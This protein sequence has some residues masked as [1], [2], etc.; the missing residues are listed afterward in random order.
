MIKFKRWLWGGVA[1][2]VALT[3][4]GVGFT[5]WQ[6]AHY[7]P[8]DA[9]QSP[10]PAALAFFLD[11]YAGARK[12]FLA[13]GDGLAARFRGVERF[14]LRVPAAKSAAE[15][16]IDGL[17]IPAQVAPRRLLLVTSGVHGVEG[18]TGSAVQRM[19][20]KEFHTR[21]AGRDRCAAGARGQPLGFCERPTLH[22]EQRGPQPQC[23]HRGCALP[24][25]ERGL[26]HGQPDDQPG[27]AGGHGRPGQ[28]VLPAAGGGADCRARHAH[29]APGGA[30]GAVPGRP[31]ASISAAAP[32]SRLCRRWRRCCSPSWPPTRWP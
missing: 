19:F 1:V 28:C 6:F 15:P 18:P 27:G 20:M 29:A 30:A 7:A 23:L 22:R 14:A 16:F 25:G 9:P 24:F 10:D 3:S 12:A 31:R 2:A 17:Y 32:W 26:P 11:D 13:Q 4:T 5:A 8:K 21:G